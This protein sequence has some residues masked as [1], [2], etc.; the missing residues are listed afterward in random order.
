MV[1]YRGRVDNSGG[2]DNR[3]A[4]PRGVFGEEETDFLEWSVKRREWGVE[5]PQ[6]TQG[7]DAPRSV[8]RSR[9][10]MSNRPALT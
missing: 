1:R 9:D 3:H 7:A 6:D 5:G 4:T 10:R 8:R 2:I